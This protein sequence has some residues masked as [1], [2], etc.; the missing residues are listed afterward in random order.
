MKVMYPY[1]LYY[2]TGLLLQAKA[3][4]GHEN[5]SKSS[6]PLVR[7]NE[8]TR[9]LTADEESARAKVLV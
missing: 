8:N 3:P 5:T 2:H 9:F 7:K 6:I 1:K 4:P